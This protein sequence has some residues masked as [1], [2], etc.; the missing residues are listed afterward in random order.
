MK[1]SRE[2]FE[3]L[4]MEQC[5][6]LY[7]VAFRLTRNQ[8]S[9]EDLVQD[10][11]LRAI[12]FHDGFD[13]QKYGIKPWLLRILHNIHTTQFHRD[14]KQPGS[15]DDVQLDALTGKHD[16]TPQVG[17]SIWEGMDEQLVKA[18]N[19]LPE[20]YRSVL[21]LWA[22]EDL[23]YQEISEVVEVPIGTVMSRLHRGRQKMAEQLQDYARENRIV[24]KPQAQ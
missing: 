2:Q 21:L 5:D 1:L 13:L 8:S 22:V 18:M 4:A 24:T 20:E 3:A 10:T 19:S 6:L 23:T 16:A 11:Y 14:K 7:R 15:M 12:R 9:A 17:S